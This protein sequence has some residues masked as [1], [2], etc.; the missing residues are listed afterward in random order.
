VIDLVSSKV[1][2]LTSDTGDNQNP[3]WSPDGRR[4]AFSSN[5]D[6]KYQIY[7]MNSDGTDQR[8]IIYLEGGGY[9]PSWSQ[10]IE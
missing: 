6:G 8:R 9:S 10:R 2:Q 1:Q 3:V 5:R 4:I 7:A